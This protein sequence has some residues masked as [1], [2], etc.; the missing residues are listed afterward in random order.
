MSEVLTEVVDLVAEVV[1]LPADRI[2]ATSRFDALGDW[3]SY[4]A[5]RLLA[6]VEVRF[7]VRLDLRHYLAI[8]V[9]GD[10][11]DA[12]TSATERTETRS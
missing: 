1:E 11:A 8:E 12:V 7:G 3:G 9:V 10:L 5:L 6:E 2:S 4:A